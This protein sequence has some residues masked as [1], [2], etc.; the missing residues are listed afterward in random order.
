MRNTS[1]G[2]MIDLTAADRV[3]LAHVRKDYA[4]EKNDGDLLLYL[5]RNFFARKGVNNPA[6][7]ARRRRSCSSAN[8]V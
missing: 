4:I 6:A 7:K 5:V 2:Y 8:G 3:R 1:S